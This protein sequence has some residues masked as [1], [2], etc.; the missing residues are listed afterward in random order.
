MEIRADRLPYSEGGYTPRGP[1][2]YWL[3]EG[4]RYGGRANYGAFALARDLLQNGYASE[5]FLR[6]YTA[7]G[8]RSMSGRLEWFAKWA[9]PSSEH[10]GRAPRRYPDM[11]EIWTN[12]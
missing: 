12:G 5:A 4:K 1:R 11:G 3:V 7:E 8:S 6:T 10:V 9:T 2:T